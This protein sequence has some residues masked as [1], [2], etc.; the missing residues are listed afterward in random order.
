M[1]KR[2]SVV[3]TLP[4]VRLFDIKDL[5]LGIIVILWIILGH[6]Y[7]KDNFYLII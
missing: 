7:I 6:S 2:M 1:E 5:A 4:V 3:Q